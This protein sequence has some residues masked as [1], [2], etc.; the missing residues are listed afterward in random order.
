[1]I[2]EPINDGL[3]SHLENIKTCLQSSCGLASPTQ[4][5]QYRVSCWVKLLTGE[6]LAGGIYQTENKEVASE[7]K[8]NNSA[9]G[10][11]CKSLEFYPPT[12]LLSPLFF[13]FFIL[14]LF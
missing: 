10:F 11:N 7:L 1:M 6:L 8:Y 14:F 12:F 2:S 3:I 13:F 9:P 5:G 4:A